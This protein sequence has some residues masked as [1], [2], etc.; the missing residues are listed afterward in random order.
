MAKK[1]VKKVAKRK[2]SKEDT[3]SV[4]IDNLI[5]EVNECGGKIVSINKRIDRIVAAMA[6]SKSVKG[7]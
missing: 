7:L 4:L 3:R 6:K 1:K 2:V 5:M